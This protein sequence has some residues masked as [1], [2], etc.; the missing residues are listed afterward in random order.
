MKAQKTPT[1]LLPHL[2]VLVMALAA[3]GSGTE[4]A[5]STTTGATTVSSLVPTTQAEMDENED[6][7]H[8]NE[9]HQHEHED[10]EASEGE[11]SS[12][13]P[14]LVTMEADTGMV[15]VVDIESWE[16]MSREPSATDQVTPGEAPST[17]E[18]GRFAFFSHYGQNR[19]TIVD[20]GTWSEGHGTH[21]H[22][23]TTA[24]GV[25]ATLDGPN[26]SHVVSHDEVFAVFFDGEGRIDVF[27]EEELRHGHLE[28]VESFIAGGPHHGVAVP[29]DGCYLSS[30][31]ADTP[32]ELPAAIG[33][34]CDGESAAEVADCPD[35]HGESALNESIVFACAD[36]VRSISVDQDGHWS[37]TSTA[38]PE[39][40][41]D[42]DLFGADYPRAWGFTGSAGSDQLIAWAG[43]NHIYVY[44]EER[45]EGR[46]RAI[47]MGAQVGI[48]GLAVL[49]GGSAVVLT[50]DGSLNR[51]DLDTASVVESV[52][53]VDPYEPDL[54]F[55]SPHHYLVAT[56][57]RVFVLDATTNQ[58]VEINIGETMT[59]G[60][61]LQFDEPVS[62]VALASG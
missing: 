21:L 61:T 56:E 49:P 35:I 7:E 2:L 44:D 59:T 19:V 50:T 36:G 57:E 23:Y 55:A 39:G 15:L 31:P 6:H 48:Y 27:D 22:H 16:I 45:T 51:I 4:G 29:V 62:G 43:A 60:R 28:M 3:C 37:A 10:E 1:A 33:L 52:S 11:H 32:E 34:F 13:Q 47:D 5:T 46:L 53:V 24:P 30:L 25:V 54:T 9:G 40:V 20:T 26:P 42:Q 14:R 8:E 41:D 12:P 38:Y 17:S 58:L 18:D